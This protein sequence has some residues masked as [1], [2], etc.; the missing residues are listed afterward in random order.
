MLPWLFNPIHGSAAG[1]PVRAGLDQFGYPAGEI[2]GTAGLVPQLPTFLEVTTGPAP[3]GDVPPP[4][5]PDAVGSFRLQRRQ[6][7]WSWGIREAQSLGVFEKDALAGYVHYSSTQT[8]ANWSDT[9]GMA[10]HHILQSLA[11]VE[12]RG[13]GEQPLIHYHWH[14]NWWTFY[15][16]L[17]LS[18][19]SNRVNPDGAFY[20][21][22]RTLDD[23]SQ[24]LTDH[25]D[26]GYH[27]GY[28]QRFWFY[29]NPAGFEVVS[30]PQ[31]VDVRPWAP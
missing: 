2:R 5:Y 18:L 30:M 24:L 9:G 19:G 29:P 26:G 27:P 3:T 11:W 22:S 15:G 6:V 14:A 7:G 17:G 16:R 20:A 12:E 13:E 23:A 4:T 28:G 31:Y 1:D 8:A 25:F 10:W 21:N